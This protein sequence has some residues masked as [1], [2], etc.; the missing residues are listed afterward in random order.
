[1]TILD[2]ES[3][4][5]DL[6]ASSPWVIDEIKVPIH[7][8]KMHYR[9]YGQTFKT[10]WRYH[11]LP[12]YLLNYLQMHNRWYYRN[13]NGDFDP[14]AMKIAGKNRDAH[15]IDMRKLSAVTDWNADYNFYTIDVENT[16]WVNVKWLNTNRE[17]TKLAL[18]EPLSMVPRN[19]IAGAIREGNFS[20]V[21]MENTLPAPVKPNQIMLAA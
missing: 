21:P 8:P 10:W 1:M 6:Q 13:S 3:S 11:N 17:N 20:M 14:H 9:P 2:S 16:L 5:I 15:K 12:I 19:E 18:R 4:K 7:L